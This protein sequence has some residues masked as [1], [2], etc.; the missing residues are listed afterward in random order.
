MKPLLKH[1]FVACFVFVLAATITASPAQAQTQAWT[2]V[3]IQTFEVNGNQ[4]VVPTIQGAQCLIANVLAVVVRLVGL[5]G[6]IMLIVGA[7]RYML[8]GGNAKGTEGAKNT[9]TFAIIGLV[10]VLSAFIILNLLAQFTG[11]DEILFF[12]IPSVNEETG[13]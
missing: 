6:F 11:V 12:N 3:C 8:S 13:L 2:G 1:L 7:F 4:V 10:I 9:M 5:A